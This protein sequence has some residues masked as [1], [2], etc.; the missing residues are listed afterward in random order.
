MDLFKETLPS[1]NQ[2]KE[3]LLDDNP[4]AE[5]EYAKQAF[6]VNRAFSQTPDTI[7]H[8]NEM[9]VNHHLDAKIQYDFYFYSLDRKKR[10]G[11]WAKYERPKE[12]DT[13][14][15]YYNCSEVKANQYLKILTDDQ[16]SDLR[17]RIYKGG[18]V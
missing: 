13:I 7:F 18:K 9:N 3:H 5:R 17:K 12:L 16:I 11:K 4:F 10:F 6:I 2:T 1:L 8:A 14:K 15:E